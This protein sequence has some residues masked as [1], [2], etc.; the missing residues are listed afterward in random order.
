VS[1]EKGRVDMCSHCGTELPADATFCPSCGRRVDA[2]PPDPAEVIPDVQTGEPRYYGLVKPLFVLLVAAALVIAG[3][4]VLVTSSFGIGL[5]LIVLG[6][7]LLPSF[8]AGIRRWPDTRFARASL[9]TAGRVRN[10]ADVAVQSLS[11]WSRTGRDVVRMRREQ[12]QLRRER[13][14]KIRELGVSAYSG[15][16]REEELRKA[17]KE[18]D[19]QIEANERT[20]ERAI[21]RARRRVRNERAT[22]APTEVIAPADSPGNSPHESEEPPTEEDVARRPRKAS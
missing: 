19:R 12:F 15:D 13:D 18:L 20:I 3:I 16:G 9:N 1:G 8:V 22:V 2:P 6:V 7:C 5:I 4:V 14:A 11:A 10:E 21:A 17:A